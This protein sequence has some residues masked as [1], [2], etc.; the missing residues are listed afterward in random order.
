MPTISENLL[1]ID[2]IR[3]QIRNNLLAKG[4]SVPPGT[5]FESY[6]GKVDEIPAAVVPEPPTDSD[7]WERPTD[8]LPVPEPLTNELY[9]YW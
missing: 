2:Q 3:R 9:I 7:V 1:A 5:G 4:V 8:W 6:P